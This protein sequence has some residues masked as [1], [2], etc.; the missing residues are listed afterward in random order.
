M[1]RVG[2]SGY[3]MSASSPTECKLTTSAGPKLGRIGT[4]SKNGSASATLPRRCAASPSSIGKTKREW[5]A[6]LTPSSEWKSRSPCHLQ[7][8]STFG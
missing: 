8:P 5:H 1:P 2:Y 6:S 4:Q 7:L 3:A